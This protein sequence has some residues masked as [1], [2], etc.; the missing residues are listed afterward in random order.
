MQKR[1]KVATRIIREYTTK[2]R[3]LLS[4]FE[5]C[6]LYFRFFSES[7]LIRSCCS[8]DGG[9]GHTYIVGWP[10]RMALGED[11]L[12]PSFLSTGPLRGWLYKDNVT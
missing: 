4:K 12:R 7:L 3:G 8:F 10:L 6:D 1:G 5:E 11:E 9:F 2:R